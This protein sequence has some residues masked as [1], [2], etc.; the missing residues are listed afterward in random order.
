MGAPS[1]YYCRRIQNDANRAIHLF[2]VPSQQRV[3]D[4]NH[5][6]FLDQQS[7]REAHKV[8]GFHGVGRDAARTGEAFLS[9]STDGQVK[10]FPYRYGL[11][12]FI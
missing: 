4:S 9:R 6:A 10:T 2:P 7:R 3:A 12:H 1:L 5:I 11:R 8:S